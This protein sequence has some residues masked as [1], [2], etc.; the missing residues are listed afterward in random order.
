MSNGSINSGG[1][2]R[3]TSQNLCRVRRGEY[4]VNV[5]PVERLDGRHLNLHRVV[6]NVVDHLV[7]GVRVAQ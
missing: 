5:G 1:N 6:V 3:L 4:K 7:T 2:K